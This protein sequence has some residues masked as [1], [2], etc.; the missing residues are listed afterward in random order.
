MYVMNMTNLG[1]IVIFVPQNLKEKV[2]PM[3][4]TIKVTQEDINKGIRENCLKCPVAL[5]CRRTFNCYVRVLYSVIEIS[6]PRKLIRINMPSIVDDFINDFDTGC[7][8]RQGPFEFELD[9]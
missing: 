1:E 4:T 3:K 8:Y 9:V 6:T 5:A 7:V 2:N